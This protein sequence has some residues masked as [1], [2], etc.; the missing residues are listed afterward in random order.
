MTRILTTVVIGTKHQFPTCTKN[1]S[2]IDE[3][4][5]SK[6]RITEISEDEAGN[7]RDRFDERLINLAQRAIEDRHNAESYLY[8]DNFGEAVIDALNKSKTRSGFRKELRSYSDI[9]NMT[10]ELIADVENL[11]E[12]MREAP[13]KYFEAKPQR[14]VGFNEVAAAIIPDNASEGIRKQLKANGIEVVE[15]NHDDSAS[16][17][18]AVNNAADKASVK[19]SVT[20]RVSAS[21]LASDIINAYGVRNRITRAVVAESIENVRSKLYDTYLG[22][23]DINEKYAELEATARETAEQIAD[24]M[25]IVDESSKETY[26]TLRRE[27]KD[28]PISVSEQT[29]SDIPDWNDWK[30][31]NFGKLTISNDGIPVDSYYR[32]LMEQYPQFFDETLEMTQADQLEKIVNVL[33]NIKPREIEFTAD[34]K[35]AV[36]EE[37]TSDIIDKAMQLED[38]MISGSTSVRN[39]P[40]TY[41]SGEVRLKMQNVQQTEREKARGR[42]RAAIE[43][44]REKE[45]AKLEKDRETHKKHIAESRATAKK[46][47][48]EKWAARLDKLDEQWQQEY[49]KKVRAL[50]MRR[51]MLLERQ[52]QHEKDAVQ[53]ARDKAKEHEK[54]AIR[55]VRDKSKEHEREAVQKTKDKLREKT[56]EQRKRAREKRNENSNKNHLL[57]LVKRWNSMDLSKAERSKIPET[58]QDIDTVAVNILNEGY[59]VNSGKKMHEN[60]V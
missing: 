49:D 53:K 42:E 59:T 43:K 37:I 15:Y 19:F 58:I 40:A 29:K 13:V 26:D 11:I 7:I 1:L 14:A 34:E 54:N 3:I 28:T 52:K 24:K 60:P 30:K 51:D 56:R 17:K 16:R 25:R 44:A 41:Q 6:G 38:D 21:S 2:S 46:K 4:R 9:Y 36:I 5:A 31:A 45:R 47:S 12:D 35:Q 39:D 50:D 8:A 22:K 55:D 18:S 48:D 27:I 10:D 57:K 33:D 32:E 20:N 23:G